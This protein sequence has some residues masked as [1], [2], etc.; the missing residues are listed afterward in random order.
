LVLP[1]DLPA[2]Q[3]VYHYFQKWQRKGVWQEIHDVLRQQVRESVG[4]LPNAS[5]GSIDSQTVKPT[6]KRGRSMASMAGN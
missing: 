6:E 2:H 1:K 5:A 4:K 3:T